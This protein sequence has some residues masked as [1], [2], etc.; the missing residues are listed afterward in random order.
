[1]LSGRKFIL[2]DGGEVVND[3]PHS[4]IAAISSEKDV[5]TINALVSIWKTLLVTLM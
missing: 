5:A 1:M 4:D 2:G 3:T